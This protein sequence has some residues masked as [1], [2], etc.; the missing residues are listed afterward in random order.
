[1]GIA[2]CVRRG[3]GPA[4]LQ[5][6]F[7]AVEPPRSQASFFG[8]LALFNRLFPCSDCLVGVGASHIQM[9]FKGVARGEDVVRVSCV[10]TAWRDNIAGFT[11]RAAWIDCHRGG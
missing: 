4:R 5:E 2:L 9:L 6:L 1:M 10:L 7:L 11:V 3:T 8:Q